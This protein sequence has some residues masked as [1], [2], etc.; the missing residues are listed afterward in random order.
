[1]DPL[2][3]RAR[4]LAQAALARGDATGWF[5]A[6]Y[7]EAAR[8]EATV[9][10]DDRAPNPHVLGWTRGR[11]LEGLR[12]LDVGTGLGDTAVALGL[13]GARVTAFDVSPSAIAAARARHE[14]AAGVVWRAADLCAPPR[15]WRE[16][17][18]LVVECYTLQVLPR[19]TRDGARERL[20]ELVAPG[21]TLLIVARGREPH[22]PQGEMPWPLLREEIEDTARAPFRLASWEDFM[23]EE[24]PPVRRFRAALTR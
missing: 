12:V 1:M 5:E 2:R 4:D 20:R 10:W 9:P 15:E 16:A 19:A 8:G 11:A 24:A 18:D 22:E 23:D 3:R 21:G 14:H 6:L 13:R 17:F 7:G